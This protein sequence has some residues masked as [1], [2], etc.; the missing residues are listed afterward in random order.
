MNIRERKIE[1]RKDMEE[2]R[3]SITAE[4]REEKQQRIHERMTKL[5]S[6]RLL[7]AQQQEASVPPTI[8][9]YMPFRSELDVAPL[10]EWCWQQGIRVLVPKVVADTKT[11]NLHIIHAYDDLESG[12]WGIREPHCNVPIEQDLST[13]SM[14]LVPGLAFDM[15]FGRLGYGGGFYDRFMQ[16]FAA[17][18]LKRPFAVAAAFDKQL[19]PAVPSSWHDF[20]VDGI[21]TESKMVFKTET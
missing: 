21:V 6:D 12:A 18:G 2:L 9:T 4:E 17:R 8:M 20:R 7:G 3:S 14:I 19:I 16:L 1:L 13:I 15:D 10:M 5:C 11:M